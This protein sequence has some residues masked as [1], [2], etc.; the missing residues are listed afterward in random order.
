MLRKSR[1]LPHFFSAGGLMMDGA[2]EWRADERF[3][4]YLEE[5]QNH[6]PSSGLTEVIEEIRLGTPKG[7]QLYDDL[8]LQSWFS[9]WDYVVSRSS[10]GN[11]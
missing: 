10:Q 6:H 11:F 9:F 4:G 5:L 7:R 2:G 3:L 1:W 8:Y